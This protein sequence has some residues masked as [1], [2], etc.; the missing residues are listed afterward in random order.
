MICDLELNV[1]STTWFLV[2]YAEKATTLQVSM[3]FWSRYER[4]YCI[5]ILSAHSSLD[6]TLGEAHTYDVCQRSIRAV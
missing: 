2:A 4:K 5:E 1:K 3:C 6:R